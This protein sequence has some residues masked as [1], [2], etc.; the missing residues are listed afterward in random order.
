MKKIILIITSVLVCVLLCACQNQENISSDKYADM[1][2]ITFY[3]DS[4]KITKDFIAE[5]IPEYDYTWHCDPSVVHDD[6][7]DAPAEYYTGSLPVNAGDVYIDHDL[8]Y[9]PLLDEEKFKQVNYGGEREIAYYYGDGEN[10]EYIFGT[11]PSLSNAVPL[12]MMPMMMNLTMTLMKWKTLSRRFSVRLLLIRC[13]RFL[14]S[15]MPIP[16]CSI[17]IPRRKLLI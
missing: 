14:S 16:A 15:V 5:E 4:A 17:S 3:G 13:H 9:Y 10:E 12:E 1:T 11:L 8:Q 2:V 6:V 7:K